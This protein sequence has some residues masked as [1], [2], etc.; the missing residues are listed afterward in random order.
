MLNTKL[1][2]LL[3]VAKT[4]NF[5]QAAKELSL[6]QPAVSNHINQ[7][8]EELDVEI[9]IRS[10]NQLKLTSHGEIVLM[11]AQRM[12]SLYEKLHQD[13]INDEN[14]ITQLTIG[15]THTA[16]SNFMVEV[17]AKYSSENEGVNIKIITSS[18]KKLYSKLMNYEIDLAIVEGITNTTGLNSLLLDTDY[19]VLVVSNKNKLATKSMVTINEIKKEKMILR[20]PGSGTRNLFISHLESINMSIDEFD[21]ILEVDNI[22]TIK[23]L[24]SQDFGVSIL[25]RSACLDS[26]RKGDLTMLPVENLSMV[27]ETSILYH[28]DFNHTEVL[29]DITRLYN[30]TAKMYK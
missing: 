12:K 14:E 6:T 11:Y 30:K 25:A 26:A 9:F 22:A 3:K 8:E 18:I 10:R 17:L 13:L 16:E 4:K 15:I 2:T 5:T 27:R 1:N 7:L 20:L 29:E 23:D 21:L 24:V 19:L 28:K